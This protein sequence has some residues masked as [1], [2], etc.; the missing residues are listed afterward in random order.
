MKKFG[1]LI[2]IVALIVGV[3]F[4]NLF[5]F[6]KAS[7]RIFNISFSKSVQG[8]GV[9]GTETRDIGAFSG[10]D[11]GGVF[12]VEVTAGREFGIEVAADENLLQYIRTEVQNGVLRISATERLKSHTPIRVRVSAP[13]LESI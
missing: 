5:S 9:S 11:V 13:E 4:S 1:I 7:E 12:N 6:G 3:V 10:L 8:S 2:F